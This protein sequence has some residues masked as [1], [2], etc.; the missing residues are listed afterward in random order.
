MIGCCRVDSYI[1][2]LDG[3]I[4]GFVHQAGLVTVRKREHGL[5]ARDN[6]RG[7]T[8]VCTTSMAIG[9]PLA[10]NAAPT[11]GASSRRTVERK[12]SARVLCT[13]PDEMTTS[14]W[15]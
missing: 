9:V 15:V 2:P 1:T 12:P 5:G 8:P 11:E 6:V 7:N 13:S 10:P 4:I 14:R 3:L